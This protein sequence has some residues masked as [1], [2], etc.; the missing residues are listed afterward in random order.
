MVVV[1]VMVVCGKESEGEGRGGKGREGSPRGETI[2]G[3]VPSK[4]RV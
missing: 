2:N 3:R 4:L 1:V